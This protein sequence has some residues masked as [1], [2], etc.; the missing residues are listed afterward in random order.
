ME[1]MTVRRQQ[2]IMD[3]ALKVFAKKGFNGAT[4]KEIAAEAGIAEG[5]IFRYFKTKKDILLN[6]V[7]NH[8]VKTLAETFDEVSGESDENVL[9]AIIKNRL[10]TAEDNKDLI[11][12]LFTEAQFHPEIRQQ[13]TENIVVKAAGLLEQ[14]ISDRIQKG[15]Y[16]D[17]DPKIAARS[18]AGMAGVFVI[19]KEFLFGDRII[20]FDQNT[21]IETVVDI[22][23]HGIKKRRSEE[24]D[25][26]GGN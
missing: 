19:W 10:Q 25:N 17:F 18:F 12:L 23:L 4:T 2:E 13:F 26:Y 1:D 3:A 24:E 22:F 7:G 16:R 5:T 9:K 8:V 20:A 14:Y 21:V 6:L 15:E 11:R